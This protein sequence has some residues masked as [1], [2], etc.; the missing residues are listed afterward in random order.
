MICR[1]KIIIFGQAVNKVE[2]EYEKYHLKVVVSLVSYV[3][4][5]VDFQ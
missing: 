5:N 2:V 1:K 3:A 4:R